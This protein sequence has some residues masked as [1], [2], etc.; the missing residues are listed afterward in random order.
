MIRGLWTTSVLNF[1]PSFPRTT[2]APTSMY[3]RQTMTDTNNTIEC[4][5]FQMGVT[6]SKIDSHPFRKGCHPSQMPPKRVSPFAGGQKTQSLTKKCTKLPQM[7][8]GQDR[9][10]NDV[11]LIGKDLKWIGHDEWIDH[12]HHWSSS[13][14]SPSEVDAGLSELALYCIDCRASVWA[15]RPQRMQPCRGA[16]IAVDRD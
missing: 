15:S 10:E 1:R 2:M 16:A 11:N 6:L 12:R 7:R 9:T 4:H 3:P 14:W 8:F 13:Q 5:P